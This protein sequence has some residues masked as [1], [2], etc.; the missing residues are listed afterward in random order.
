MNLT[1][2]FE[3]SSVVI[4][5]KTGIFFSLSDKQRGNGLSGRCGLRTGFGVTVDRVL[6]NNL[7]RLSE[8]VSYIKVSIRFF[9]IHSKKSNKPMTMIEIVFALNVVIHLNEFFL[10]DFLYLM[11]NVYLNVMML[12]VQAY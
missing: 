12:V 2:K 9:L 6:S 1:L 3:F 5:V 10:F 7:I 4:T 11:M 8:C